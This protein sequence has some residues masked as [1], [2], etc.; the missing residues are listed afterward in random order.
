M[1]KIALIISVYYENKIA[2]YG[3][4]NLRIT[5]N[6][7]FQNKNCVNNLS[8]KGKRGVPNSR[9]NYLWLCEYYWTACLEKSGV[10]NLGIAGMNSSISQELLCK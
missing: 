9:V 2:G 7:R 1:R 10:N 5:A 4:K 3:V 6:G 8:F